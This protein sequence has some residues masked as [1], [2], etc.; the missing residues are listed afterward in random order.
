[1]K[2]EE[3]ELLEGMRNCYNWCEKD[4]D[5]TIEM[6]SSARDREPEEVKTTLK[7]LA[8]DYSQSKEYQKLRAEI[9]AEFP[10]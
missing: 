10:F 9:P 3:K 6:V 4:F 1:M 7:R 5:G 8:K 2:Y